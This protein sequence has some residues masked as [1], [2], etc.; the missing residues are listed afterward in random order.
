M[1]PGGRHQDT[2]ALGWPGMHQ[3]YFPLFLEGIS[4][5]LSQRDWCLSLLIA[6]LMV[7]GRGR[8]G[9]YRT[10]SGMLEPWPVTGLFPSSAD[11]GSLGLRWLAW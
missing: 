7:R 3:A 10:A 1:I 2:P 6:S 9:T 11:Q 8:M 5:Y 4:L